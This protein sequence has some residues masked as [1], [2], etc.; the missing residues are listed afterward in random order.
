L[1]ALAQKRIPI[2]QI[3]FSK[4]KA[5]ANQDANSAMLR[6]P[7]RMNVIFC[8]DGGGVAKCDGKANLPTTCMAV[9]SF[10]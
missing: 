8:L 10:S 1:I 4:P 9:T 3:Y 5:L 6:Y 2:R 7:W